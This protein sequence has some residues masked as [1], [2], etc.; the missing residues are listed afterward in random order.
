MGKK[1][2]KNKQVANK[3][4][5]EKEK[6]QKEES[7]RSFAKKLIFLS[8]GGTVTVLFLMFA[9]LRLFTET[10]AVENRHVQSETESGNM[11][12]VERL[13]ASTASEIEN[14]KWD[15]AE[16]NLTC[17]L[18]LPGAVNLDIR[19]C[20]NEL[21]RWTEFV[22]K[23]TDRQMYKFFRN[24]N[25]F[26]N[27]EAY[28][29]VLIMVTALQRDLG[30]GYNMS[31]VESGA[32]DDI[33]ST[34]FFRDSKDLFIH[35]YFSPGR[36]GSCASM[37]VLMTAVGRRLGY[38]LKLVT[39][40]AHLFA[41]WDDGKERFNIETAGRGLLCYPDSHYRR[42]PHPISDSEIQA[43]G[44][45]KSLSPVEELSA[46]LEVRAMCLKENRRYDEALT[47]F[48]KARE[49]RLGSVLLALYINDINRIRR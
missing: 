21:S 35:G 1:S 41:R 19:S 32:M 30:A 39:A 3:A 46:F 9:V 17:A 38:P 31:L 37:P 26:N 4:N 23:E 44:Y 48:E 6:S 29:K 34:R 27:S 12:T 33:R 14:N 2:R 16:L 28:F 22:R 47:A 43:E 15:I 40:K 24:P 8:I 45:L 7:G 36:S 49:F 10:E 13:M 18:N 11:L 20:L 42:F 25:D 5:T